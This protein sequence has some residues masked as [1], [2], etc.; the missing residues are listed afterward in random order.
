MLAACDL[1]VHPARYEAYGLGVHE[2]LSR[3]LPV[4]VSGSAGVAERIDDDLRSLM[5]PDP[6][7]VDDLVARLRLWHGD[8]PRWQRAAE[9]AGAVLR[10]RTWDHMADE[11]VRI[12]E[13]A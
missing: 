5:L 11:I 2:A 3:A 8:P 6:L 10:S 12:V 9:R 7:R 1:L 4:I 13:D